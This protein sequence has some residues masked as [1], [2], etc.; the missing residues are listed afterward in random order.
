M[1]QLLLLTLFITHFGCLSAQFAQ[2]TQGEGYGQ[3]VFYDLATRTGK[4]VDHT[5][6]DIAFNVSGRSSGI[7]INEAVASSQ[8]EELRATA[9]YASTATD[10]ATAD[11]SQITNRLYN[12]E[13]SWDDGAFNAAATPGD[14]LDQGW[15]AYSTETQTV[16]GNRVFFVVTPDE[17]YHKVF[18]SS[19]AGG[20]YTFVHGPLDG[21]TTD[22]VTIA[23]NQFTGK[24]LAYF[25]FT[26]GVQDL[27]PDA[28]DLLFTRYVTPLAAGP[29]VILDYT[30]TGVLQN[31][32]TSVARLSGVDP[33]T[34]APPAEATFSDTLTTI[35]HD[36]KRFIL[37]TRTYVFPDDLVYFVQT[38]DSLYRIQFIDFEG[39]TT[40][41][42]VF[43]LSAEATTATTNLPTGIAQSRLYP[44]P[45]S[46]RLTLEVTATQA[47][48]NL[49]LEVIDPTGRTLL[50][51]RV[52]ALNTG[53]NQ[54]EVPLAGLPPGH[55][56]LRLSGATGVLTH[57]FVKQ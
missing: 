40:G 39:N 18:V 45:A 37:S 4:S 41:V 54:V 14:P 6:W 24:T 49:S 51:S 13:A 44:N 43:K 8:T 12:G 55:Y 52:R 7:L 47:A 2:I 36:W 21:S 27:E 17:V 9:V 25:S 32:G 3:A 20:S 33:E 34:V 48:E 16:V 31:Q 35:G 10:F 38:P 5:S 11:T 30:V 22:T 53:P 1:K 28:W 57:H 29:G 42:S 50:A 19:L 23:K 26:D 46:E 56:F 15:G